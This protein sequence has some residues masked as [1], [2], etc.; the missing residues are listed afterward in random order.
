[1]K[2]AGMFNEPP[3][4]FVQIINALKDLEI[5]INQKWNR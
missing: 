1:M 3:P 4:P 5:I 2:G